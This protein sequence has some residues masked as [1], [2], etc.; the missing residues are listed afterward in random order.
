MTR[1]KRMYLFGILAFLVAIC[2]V[3][4]GFSSAMAADEEMTNL[5]AQIDVLTML[6][7]GISCVGVVGC[8]IVY[9]VVKR[10][11]D[12]KLGMLTRFLLLLK[13][14]GQD[15]AKDLLRGNNFGSAA[16]GMDQIVSHI[17][18][19]EEV[20][21]NNES[22]AFVAESKAKSAMSQAAQARQQGEAARC[23]GLLSAART[24]DISVQGIRDDSQRLSAATEK[25]QAGAI[26]QQQYISGAVCAMEQMNM[27]VS[28]SASNA[29]AAAHDAEQTQEFAHKGADVVA[30]TLESISSVSGNSQAMADRVASLGAQ[31]EGVGKIMSVIN[32]IADQTNLLALN[33][34]IE[35]ARAGEAGRGFAVVADEVR[36]LAEKTVDAT[37]DVGVAIEGIQNQVAQTISGVEE[38]ATQADEAA[39]LASQSGEALEEIV[40]IVGASADRIRSI[41]SAASEQSSASEEVTRTLNEVHAIS[42]DTGEGMVESSVSVTA[43]RDRVEELA[44]MTGVFRLVGN[45]EVQ[46]VITS[47]AES[48]D[49]QSGGRDR[50]E[51]AVKS[52]LRR[53][54]F[55]ELVYITD[56]SG[57]Q[58]VSNMG[59]QVTGFSDDS[60]AFGTKWNERPWFT[61]VMET[62]TFSVSDVY[63]SSASGENCITVSGPFFNGQGVVKGVI[64]A[65]VRVTV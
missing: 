45:G 43:L 25:A 13:E 32:D 3:L 40:T 56:E 4:G 36:K 5:L 18:A 7:V 22:V 49:V 17:E 30:K 12:S 53:S 15:E 37:H 44:T 34:A 54:D 39:G 60:S 2:T 10:R 55:L 23:Q 51:S 24:L 59:G 14:G 57:K 29:E 35:A 47:L 8:L 38:M 19:L 41:A 46:D 48:T 62:K 52:A 20:I 6:L 58:T 65:D 16:L 33:A 31:A 21:T 9:L 64:A 27:A 50:Q 61:N 26:E 42:K 1:G 63:V 28:E 11:M